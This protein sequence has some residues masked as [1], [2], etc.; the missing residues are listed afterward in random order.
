MIPSLIALALT[1]LVS[2]S[3]WADHGGELRSPGMSPIM[4]ALMWAGAAF[5]LGMAVIGIVTVLSRRPGGSPR[6]P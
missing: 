6:D 1:V 5:L 4:T 2:V 3:A